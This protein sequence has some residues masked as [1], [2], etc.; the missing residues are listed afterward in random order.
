MS[1]FKYF[2]KTE[3]PWI[4]PAVGTAVKGHCQSPASACKKPGVK[5]AQVNAHMATT[6]HDRQ[7]QAA[8]RR[9]VPAVGTAVKGHCQSPA[10]ACKKPGVKTAQVNAHMAT[11]DHDRQGQAAH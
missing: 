9:I 6:D 11:M 2:T 10:S 8:H 4:V 1:A 5:T 7:G 3:H